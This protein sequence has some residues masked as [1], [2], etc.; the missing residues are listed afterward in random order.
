MSLY[1][2]S[3]QLSSPIVPPS[4]KRTY[5]T[6]QEVEQLLKAGGAT[7]LK[8]KHFFLSKVDY[9]SASD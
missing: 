5:L 9:F 6:E 2:E 8:V 3:R 1:Q 4:F 7:V